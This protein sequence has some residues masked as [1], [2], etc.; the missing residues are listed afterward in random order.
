MH[1]L[2]PFLDGGI[3]R[4]STKT[5]QAGQAEGLAGGFA[6]WRRGRILVVDSDPLIRKQLIRPLL[7]NGL[8]CLERTMLTRALNVVRS[9][10]L[11]AVV[12][13][14]ELPGTSG[15][16]L[17]KA[18]RDNPP[19]PNLKIIMTTTRFSGDEMAALLAG[20]AD[21]YFCLPLS[22]V[23]IVARVKAIVKHKQT[24]D[25]TDGLS[26]QLLDLNMQL[27]RG[28]HV[29]AA[30][31]IQARNALVLALARLVEYRSTE[32][33][34]HL[35]RMQRYCTI[36]AQEAAGHANFTGLIDPDFI[37]TIECCAPLHDIG[38]VGLPDHILLRAGRLDADERAIMQTHAVIGA[39][40]LQHVA[41]HFGAGVGFLQMAI[42]IARHHHEHYD[43]SGYPDGLAGNDIPLAARI[44]A[45]ADA[46][47]SLRSRRAQ[48]PGLSH[49]STLQIMLEAS[50]GKFDPALLGVFNGCAQQF[51][52]TFREI[53]DSILFE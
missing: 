41:R 48:R 33:I 9:E 18:I 46:Y 47:D 51:T 19:C 32:T 40:T 28:L 13:A 10:P 35:S 14:V 26:R 38:N 11:E 27:E 2:L 4:F 12:L 16:V 53:P 1:V 29:Q 6:H 24:Q 31:L 25:R 42:D 5:G 44:A 52:R 3:R 49:A 21:D 37:Q 43:G 34:A 36:L 45:I 39:E 17:L 30:D 7:A 20:G 23:Q 50:P 22:N 15:R 8:T